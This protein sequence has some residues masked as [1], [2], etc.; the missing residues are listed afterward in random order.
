MPLQTPSDDFNYLDN[1]NKLLTARVYL[2][3]RSEATECIR[4]DT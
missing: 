1:Y 4:R 2:A 3:P